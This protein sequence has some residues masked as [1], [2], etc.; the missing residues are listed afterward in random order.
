MAICPPHCA[1]P[2]LLVS[3][4]ALLGVGACGSTGGNTSDAGPADD[5]AA[6][7]AGIA[8]AAMD[9]ATTPD[10]D[11]CAP[12]AARPTACP[13]RGLYAAPVAVTLRGPPMQ[14][15][16]YTLDGTPP[17][18]ATATLYTAPIAVAPPS[19][20]GLVILRARAGA[21]GPIITHSYVFPN[22]VLD[23]PAAPAGFPATW[24]K[25]PTTAGDYAM[26]PSVLDDRPSA[27]LALA[28]LPTISL[29][30]AQRDLFDVDT[31]IYMNPTQEGMAWERATS[32]EMF[33]GAG[34]IELQV[35]AGV[36]IQGGSS[37]VGWKSSKLSMRLA[38]RGIYGTPHLN[39]KLFDSR[40]DEL[41]TVVLDAHLNFTW[42]HPDATQR[43]RADYIRDRFTADLQNAVGSLAP[44]G[45]YVHL[46]LNGLYWGLYE[47]HECAEE[48]FAAD[49]LG[50]KTS[51]YDVLKHNGTTV[52]AGDDVAWRAMFDLAR[53]GL[54]DAGRYA[55]IQSYLD[56]DDFI[57]YMIVNLWAGNDDWP[58]HNWYAARRRPPTAGKFRFFSWDAEHVLK[59]VAVNRFGV[60]N[61]DTPGELFQ[62]LRA[63]P[64]FRA[65]F[66]ERSAA[67]AAPGKPLD[68]AVAAALY[69][70]R[71]DE[72]RSSIVL[73]SARWGDT[74]RP[75]QA[76]G[77]TD[78]QAEQTWLTTVFFP[79]RTAVFLGQVPP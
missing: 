30:M 13:G 75:G 44:H 43:K 71:A 1:A 61:A 19:D 8:V 54:D 37:I 63:N 32:V 20:R 66:A 3:A 48:H 23:Q 26:D 79:G 49:Y 9:A 15:V 42:I 11:P 17:D 55:A 46:Y 28:A 64:T 68:G 53:Q 21:D 10:A 67:L 52:I 58:V 35:D 4:F 6:P 36:R 45:R 14:S 47:L 5:T 69:G 41:D 78:W 22:R 27:V 40:V 31:G 56:V 73:E 7:D 60:N 70:K 72:I 39:A 33:G 2:A 34:G 16:Y 50:G 74:R 62:A 29:V 51:E 65:A 77:V 24:G 25:G 59:D 57:A 76:Y 38:F 12:L 18:P